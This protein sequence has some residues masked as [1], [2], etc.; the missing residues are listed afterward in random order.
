MDAMI[1]AATIVSMPASDICGEGSTINGSGA[2]VLVFEKMG[3]L[4]Q[5]ATVRLLSRFPSLYHGYQHLYQ[6]HQ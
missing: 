3:C 2:S 1:P 6:Y 5:A 4:I